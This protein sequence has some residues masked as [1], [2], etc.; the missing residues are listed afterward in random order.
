MIDTT[1]SE[2]LRS[3]GNLTVR[4]SQVSTKATGKCNR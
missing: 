1:Q 3:L 2:P 4:D